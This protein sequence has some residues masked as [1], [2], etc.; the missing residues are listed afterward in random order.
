MLL[1]FDKAYSELLRLHV[2]VFIS[3]MLSKIDRV[4]AVLCKF[5]EAVFLVGIRCAFKF[6]SYTTWHAGQCF[7]GSY[8]LVTQGMSPEPNSTL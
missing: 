5:H 3:F 1:E 2:A 8:F 6:H 7:S 4:C